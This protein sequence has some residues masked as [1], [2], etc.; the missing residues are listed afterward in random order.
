MNK[1]PAMSHR[2]PR[3]SPSVFHLLL[4]LS[5]TLHDGVSE[6][7]TIV[8]SATDDT[9]CPNESKCF[10]LTQYASNSSLSSNLSNITLELQPGTHSL[11]SP[12]IVSDISSFAMRGENATLLCVE[13]FN[14]SYTEYVYLGGISFVNCGGRSSIF[15]DHIQNVRNFTIENS[16]F[17]MDEPFYIDSTNYILV[18]N[19][20]FTGSP[21]GVFSISRPLILHIRDCVFSDNIQA[22]ASS[23]GVITSSGSSR[24]SV[25]I[26]NSIFKN[27]RMNTDH[28]SGAFMG[29]GQSITITNS[30]FAN[31]SYGGQFG[32][33]AITLGY[34]SVVISGSS[35]RDNTGVKSAGALNLVWPDTAETVV[36]ISQCEFLN[37]T[38]TGASLL[39]GAVYVS[40]GKSSITVHQVTFMDNSGTHGGALGFIADNL[41]I[42]VDQSIFVGNAG[43]DRANGGAIE[44][45]G[46]NVS[47]V[48]KQSAFTNNRVDESG[49]VFY[50]SGDLP[51]ISINQSTFTKNTASDSGGVISVFYLEQR[52][53][54]ELVISNSVFSNNSAS[55]CGVLHVRASTFRQ[56]HTLYGR[57]VQ[58]N[59][60]IFTSNIQTGTFGSNVICL[61]NTNASIVHSN[62]SH[63]SGSGHAGALFMQQG[64][65]A[66]EGSVFDNNRA[67]RDGGVIYGHRNFTG[68]FDETVFTNNRAAD[69][70]GVMYLTDSQVTIFNSTIGFNQ[71]QT[72]G[73]IA[74]FRGSLEIK[75][76]NVFNNTAD[77]GS[78]I[79][80]CNGAEV[81][82]SDHFFVSIDPT[83]TT[84]NCILYATEKMSSDAVSYYGH[85]LLALS[86]SIFIMA[87]IIILH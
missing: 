60:S 32:A 38:A 71:A 72:G 45:L 22:S 69:S 77:V 56:E 27:N 5:G 30:T 33:G 54:A 67:G 37:N 53:D 42:L 10:T 65:L 75:N 29:T 3:I 78:V 16:I 28:T 63:N 20:T 43:H 85:Y 83:R 59:R 74:I 46:Y 58:V 35:F 4:I 24:S 47:L 73:A 17:K 25:T 1:R 39:G 36:L 66:V 12:L 44:G 11:D 2:G 76:S 6:T 15:E 40:V 82:V 18:A 21:R 57:N 79:S 8:P 70:G 51:I 84:R 61:T 62:F 14:V 19:S 49:G 31:N 50:L 64:M 86:S 7:F 52:G 48:V 87:S 9:S 23:I 55:R 13:K 81:N 41:Y 26:E 34:Q 80:A 68:I